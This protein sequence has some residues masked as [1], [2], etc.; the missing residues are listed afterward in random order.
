MGGICL[1]PQ[2]GNLSPDEEI[3]KSKERIVSIVDVIIFIR[4]RRTGK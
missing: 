1:K 2:V 4:R 3:Q